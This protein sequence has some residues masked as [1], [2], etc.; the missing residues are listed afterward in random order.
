MKGIAKKIVLR[1]L[2]RAIRDADSGAILGRGLIYFWRGRLLIY[3]YQ[4][5]PLRVSFET[6]VPFSYHRRI[7]VFRMAQIPD[8]PRIA[9]E[10][11]I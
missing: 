3:G 10:E 5:P 7:L 2:G 6:E 1:L 9:A 8:F 11:R 4:G